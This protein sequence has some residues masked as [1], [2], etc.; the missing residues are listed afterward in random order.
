[1]EIKKVLQ[2]QDGTK[3]IIIPK[4]ASISQGDYVLIKKVGDEKC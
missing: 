1:M 4:D 3:Y 2:R